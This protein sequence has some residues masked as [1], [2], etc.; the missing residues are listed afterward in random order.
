MRIMDS[1]GE[2]QHVE[3]ILREQAYAVINN[4]PYM[5]L[6]TEGWPGGME[7]DVILAR[8]LGFDEQVEHDWRIPRVESVLLTP[9]P[10]RLSVLAQEPERTP[11]RTARYNLL[12]NYARMSVDGRYAPAD[13]TLGADFRFSVL[14]VRY[15]RVS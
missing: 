11:L 12:S 15:R 13:V 5:L 14:A 4:D 1:M 2:W 6:E 8:L 9:I 7:A 3:P 10:E